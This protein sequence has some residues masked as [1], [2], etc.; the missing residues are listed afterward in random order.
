MA[1]HDALLTCNINLTLAN[2]TL[3]LANFN[4]TLARLT[5]SLARREGQHQHHANLKSMPM[6]H[7]IVLPALGSEVS[8]A[9]NLIWLNPLDQR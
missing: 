6:L 2:L 1:L 9:S 7:I 3:S 4:L 8:S 5:L